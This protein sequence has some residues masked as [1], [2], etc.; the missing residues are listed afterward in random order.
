[1]VLGLIGILLLTDISVAKA[2]AVFFQELNVCVT[3]VA[4]NLYMC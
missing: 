2:T 3:S 4:F 1:M